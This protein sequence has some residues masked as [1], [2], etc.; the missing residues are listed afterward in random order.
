MVDV[1]EAIDFLQGKYGFG[2]RYAI[3]GH[4]A[5]ATLGYQLLMNDPRPVS[6]DR[7]SRRP[8]CVVGI[9]GIYDLKLVV[10]NHA[11]MPE[12]RSFVTGAFG[13]EEDEWER[14]SPA[15]FAGYEG[16]WSHGVMAMVVR[17]KGDELVETEQVDVMRK[18]LQKSLRGEVLEYREFEGGHD[19]VWEK[20]DQVAGLI[21]ELVTKLSM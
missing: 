5:G 10:A 21:Y 16:N 18:R 4:S 8:I 9:A 13:S 11:T 15:K 3:I 6:K 2:E 19:E 17:L 12:Y 1:R 7:Y 14:A 20:G